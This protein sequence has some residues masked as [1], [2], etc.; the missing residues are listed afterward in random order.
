[1]FVKE[2]LCLLKEEEEEDEE[3]E[4]EEEAEEAEEESDMVL[5]VDLSLPV[6]MCM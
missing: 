2:D 4:S 1:L 3:S 6:G 5:Y